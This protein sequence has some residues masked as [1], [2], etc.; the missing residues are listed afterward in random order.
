MKNIDKTNKQLLIELEQLKAKVDKLEKS[1]IKHN[2]IKAALLKSEERYKAL[3][4]N[5]P[6]SY[7]SLD[8]DGNF[9]DVNPTWLNTLGYTREE[10]IGKWFG[11]FLRDDFVEHFKK[12][13]PEFKKAGSISDVQ[14]YM[15]KKNGEHIYITFEGCIGYTHEDDFK[16]TYCTFKDITVQK[17]AE[18]KIKESE[19]NLS[20]LIN[21]RNESIW[22]I[23]SNYNYINFNNFYRDVYL[24][25][26]NIELKP[27]MNGLEIY[28]KELKTFWKPKYDYALSGK[29][30]VFEFSTQTENSFHYYEVFLNPII[31]NNKITGVSALS[32][33]ITERLT[34][35]EAGKKVHNELMKSE[36]R[37]RN[38]YQSGVIGIALSDKKHNLI[39]VNPYFCN[40]LGYTED[41]LKTKTFI[42]ITHP[43]DITASKIA[44][45][46]ANHDEQSFDKIEKRYIKKSGQIIYCQT[47]VSEMPADD[48]IGVYNLATIEDITESK[49]AERLLQE[50]ELRYKAL[51]NASF[52]G[53]VIHDKGLI[54]ECNKGLADITGFSIDELIGMDGLLLI[55]E[56]S[57]NKVKENI[58]SG[59]EKPYE[60]IGIKKNGE[61][62]S[63]RLE[64]RQ[65]PYK[66][67][68]VR[69]VEFRDITE[70]KKAEIA[71]QQS[72]IHFRTLFNESPIPLW[73][74]DFSEIKI[75]IDKLKKQKVENFREYFD[76][77]PEAVIEIA[78]LVKIINI[79]NATL[80][81]HEAKSKEELIKGL[82]KNFTEDLYIAFKEELI[83]IAEGKTNYSFEGV[84]KTLKGNKRNIKLDWNVLPGFEN[85]LERVF[86]TT[87]DI[88]E[89]KEMEEK[90]RQEKNRAQQYLNIAEV[91]M[92]SIDSKGIV[93]LIN[94]EG[95]EILGY[96]EEEILGHNWFDKFIPEHLRENVKG[97]SKKVFA[98]E[99]ES[100]K[101]FENEILTKHGE[102]KIIAWHN[103]VYKDSEGKVLG[104]LSS[105]EDITERK[106][107]EQ[108]IKRFSRI[109]EDSLNEIFLFDTE[110][111]KFSQVNNAAI[112]NLG[113]T[114]EELQK[115]TPLDFKPE[116]TAESFA[117]L[118]EPLRKGEQGKIVFETIHKRKDKSLYN[119]EVHLQIS[120]FD[121][122]SLFVA[123]IMDI[124]ERKLAEDT[125]KDSEAKYKRVSDNSPAVLYQFIM[126]NE[127]K[128]SYL[129]I[130][131]VIESILGISA[132]DI[133]KN[134][135]K[136]LNMVHP[137]DLEMFQ[138]GIMKSAESMEPFPLTFRFLKEKKVI[139]VEA[140]GIPTKMPN[141]DIIWDGFLLD[142]TEKKMAEEELIQSLKREKAQAD[143]VRTT[144]VAIAFGYPDGSLGNCNNAFLVLTGYSEEELKGISWN[145]ILTPD[146]WNAIETEELKKL[147]PENN[148][149]K[150]EKEYIHKSG[151]IIP[152]ELLV[153]AKFDD[154]NNI[155]NLIGFIT[156]I[157]ERKRVEDEL[158]QSEETHR[159]LLN[160]L[161]SGVVVHA[162]NTSIIL[163]N[164]SAC[165]LLGLSEDQLKGKKTIDLQ[166][167]F[168]QY[169][170]STMPVEKYPVNI[171]LST[172]KPIS[173]MVVG[174]NHTQSSDIV[175]L[176]VNGFFVYD[177]SGQIDNI[178]IT[179]IDI[180]EQKLIDEELKKHRDQLEKLV[181]ERTLELENKNKELDNTVKVFVGR[182]M[183]IKKLQERI[184]E[185]EGK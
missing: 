2:N 108:E 153:T 96:T 169:D 77:R 165:S 147:N 15:K 74:E 90:L 185:L 157:T 51:H 25:A 154:K 46:K 79:N 17:H 149:V 146:K 122:Q 128:T 7:Q 171:M 89:R 63:L 163:A 99:I 172:K 162:P 112:K 117:E 138:K 134:Q 136:L 68:E 21:N 30:L 50:S 52:G 114:M 72:E 118:V 109:F 76:D 95:C 62:Y 150:Y 179:F 8:I 174:A 155:L 160:N 126:T 41:E 69:V 27:G 151:N 35:D 135:S 81:L 156:D 40:M 16:Q 158:R 78:G 9:I 168:I 5:A 73:E 65:I 20:A 39:T 3:F 120:K 175:W 180:T 184:R 166:W 85:S 111:L 129:Y 4:N 98:G 141:D 164:P 6:L 32:I 177:S 71:L 80:K 133:I 137:E 60:S 61:Q 94:P 139:W 49:K 170:G 121:Q 23:D 1:N 116:F 107:V 124:T 28:T 113:Y 14:F 36:A 57:R 54:L 140:C 42:D 26:F 131:N 34:K 143:I 86:I 145:T 44:L 125:L 19:A 100:V 75:S 127:G 106:K 178:I 103:A 115:M 59:Y 148:S 24:A 176:L 31:T 22:S 56:E 12:N 18:E 123:I 37:F 104:I 181:T 45:Q 84:V 101:Y 10:V 152:I 48:G 43:D 144:P 91:M 93:N 11:D 105:G 66:G 110:S 58:L 53:I 183:T 97:V 92:V 167:K 47:T 130:S 82:D 182:E 70:T 83:A 38:I 173:N 88:T 55:E 102:E 119:V 67:K 13:F 64:A 87:V 33:D 29:K 142:I 161:N 159:N 132:D